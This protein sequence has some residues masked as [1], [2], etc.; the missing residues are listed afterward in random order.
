MNSKNF[1]IIIIEIVNKKNTNLSA[2]VF[3]TQIVQIGLEKRVVYLQNSR[4]IE[5]DLKLMVQESAYL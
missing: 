2:C 4:E 3:V 5:N 1:N